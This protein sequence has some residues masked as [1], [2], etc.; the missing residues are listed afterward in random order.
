MICLSREAK[1]PRLY[2]NRQGLR[3]LL[4]QQ[5]L[6]ALRRQGVGV[7]RFLAEPSFQLARL[8]QANP[9]RRLALRAQSLG[10]FFR[11]RLPGGLLPVGGAKAIGLEGGG[12]I[13]VGAPADLVLI[14][15]NHPNWMPVNNPVHQLVHTEDG[16]AVHT[17]LAGGR[18]IVEN[19]RV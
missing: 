2:P 12:R 4:P 11:R 3:L 1:A 9:L 16:N 5:P 10:Q 6:V 15:T 19:R 17:V 18:V 7:F 8:L 14:D 13:E